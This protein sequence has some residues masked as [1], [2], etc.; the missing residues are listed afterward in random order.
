VN[1]PEVE[2]DQ[3]HVP[4]SVARTGLAA[5][6]LVSMAAC[7]PIDARRPHPN[8][9]FVVV[10]TLRADHL[11]AYGYARPTSPAIDAFAH[12]AV[13]FDRAYAAASW[14]K[15]SVASMITGRYPAALGI[16]NIFSRLPQSAVTLAEILKAAGYRTAGVVSHVMLSNQWQMG[17]GQGYDTYIE[18]EA[19]G[20]RHISTE[21]VTDQAI[22]ILEDLAGGS[23]PFLL[24][25]HYFDPHF[26]YL[27]HPETTFA[28]PRSESLVGDENIVELRERI[29]SLHEGDFQFL[30]DRYDEEIR[31]TDTG[32][33]RL[34]R[35]L[36]RLELESDT[37]VVFAS[38]HGEQFG[39]RGWIG[40]TPTLH[41]MVVHVP[42]IIRVPGAANPGR[43]VEQP[44]SLV[45]LTP[46][47]LA[48][49]DVEPVEP[50]FQARSFARLLTDDAQSTPTIAPGKEG[51]QAGEPSEP[52]AGPEAGDVFIEI[53]FPL[54]DPRIS[55]VRLLRRALVGPR[56]KLIADDATGSLELYDLRD[57]PHETHNLATERP[58]LRDRM[59]AE[60]RKRIAASREQSVAPEAVDLS[61][62][63]LD[64][65]RKLGYVEER[66]PD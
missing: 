45:A 39:E 53:D 20:H 12:T 50:A 1:G 19:R 23:D 26:D 33:G 24:F 21:H 15:P 48:L 18:S 57:D 29:P 3:P 35:A 36:G 4:R 44:V 55:P 56:F 6:L 63:D 31:H 11:G 14:T 62:R 2:L 46:T 65:L 10:D 27:D 49:L 34:L 60:L 61:D 40:H 38:D 22:E 52:E 17:F 28:A 54:Q 9:L 13:R 64:V 51:K 25:V 47:L 5:L 37:V 41:E 7:T 8:L 16:D 43:S 59:L 30:R 58:A 42:L 32:I 66:R